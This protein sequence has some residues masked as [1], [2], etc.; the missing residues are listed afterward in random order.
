MAVAGFQSPM[1]FA[2]SA[3]NPSIARRWNI[4]R[5]LPVL[6]MLAAICLA[7]LLGI[8][9]A[10]ADAVALVSVGDEWRF[11]PG[12]SE[13]FDS[14]NEPDFDDHSWYAG[15]SGFGAS[16]Y[17]ENTLFTGISRGSGGI[18]FRREFVVSDMLAIRSL[19]LRCDW[20]GGF[21][22]FLNGVE[23]ARRNLPGVPGTPVPFDTPASLRYAG[24]AE[25]FSVTNPRLLLRPGT[26][27]LA[28]QV[29]PYE[30]GW[31]DVVLVP[32]LL[33]NFTR[34]PYLQSVLQDRA[35]VIWRTPASQGGQ[36]EFGA[37]ET[38]GGIAVAPVAAAQEVTL[39]GLKPGTRYS[40]RVRSGS[41][42]QE[43]VSPVSS[44]RTLPAS[45]NLDFLLFGDSGAGSAAQ[46]KVARQMALAP[47]D[48]VLHLGDVIYPMFTIGAA[49]TRCLSVYRGMLRT[50]P[51]FFAWGNHDLNAG[52]EPFLSA[53]RQPT[54]SVSAEEHRAEGTLP[55]SFFSFD[56]G[57]VH[58][59][60]LFAPY[61]SQYQMREGC[62]QL[63]WLE[64]DLTATT[65]PWKV[66]L[67]HHPVN[68][69][70]VH[71]F[72]DYNRNR[73]E[74]R[75]ELAERIMPLAARFGVQLVVSGHDHN[76][77]RFHV[78]RGTHT[79]VTG[80]GGIFLYGMSQ[81]D[82]NSALFEARWHYTA[83]QVRGDMLR[84]T[85]VDAE[86]RVFD[87]LEW[88]RTPPDS[89]DPDGD[90]L[91]SFA[92]TALGTR[93]DNPDT[94]GDGLS[95]GWEFLR[96]GHP[97]VRSTEPAALRLAP[98]LAAPLPR[99]PAELAALPGE[100][101]GVELRWLVA[102]GYQS[103]IEAADQ[104]GGR[105]EPVPVSPGE[106]SPG[107]GTQRLRLSASQSQRFFRVRLIAE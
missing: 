89:S 6:R 48:L 65:K 57:D 92:E 103:V 9:V 105:W 70:G 107:P 82:P 63:R 20:Q 58:F 75:Q 27:L 36:V 10:R 25:N 84:L 106:P 39:T 101:G 66:L 104:S 50:M 95:D 29:Q 61:F 43:V 33:A 53:F 91:S 2:A 15:E 13:F 18:C 5:I 55:E 88:R 102:A 98:F 19:T 42:A 16:R 72:D 73:I 93:P 67:M 35:T 83:V 85:P 87:A 34:G 78:V 22:A 40:Y 37:G 41:G 54:N 52:T 86:G 23:I 8:T 24:V 26:N 11:Q 51:F 99:P 46:F 76:Y 71:R 56:A 81:L 79:L 1:G 4:R 30:V 74:D 100:H 77:E 68:T 12:E 47:A 69:S 38:L 49:D 31:L 14:W 7:L 45:G 62:S 44:F 59:V 60:V 3:L 90:G 17:G 32:E 64:A 96:G 21:V 80:G 97:G 28:I 94:D